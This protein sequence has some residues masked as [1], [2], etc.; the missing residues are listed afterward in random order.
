MKRLFSERQVF[1]KFFAAA[2]FVF[3][4][5]PESPNALFLQVQI[6][7]HRRFMPATL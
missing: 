2:R 4:A 7:L 3:S 1:W 5:H 6:G